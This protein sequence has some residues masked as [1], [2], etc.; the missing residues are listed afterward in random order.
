MINGDLR[1]DLLF[2]YWIFLWFLLFYYKILPYNPKIFIIIGLLY[3]CI[4]L[5][6]QFIY[7]HPLLGLFWYLIR[8]II[9]KVIPLYLIWNVSVTVIDILFGIG[10]FIVYVLYTYICYGSIIKMI[11]V[12][13]HRINYKN[14]FYI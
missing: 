6:L 8:T 12:F 3:S 4:D 7:L 1:K 5:I 2:S 10:L 11:E 13:K 14:D 9:I